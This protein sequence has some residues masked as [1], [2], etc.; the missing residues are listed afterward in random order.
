MFE[1]DINTNWR[2]LRGVFLL[3]RVTFDTFFTK[4]HIMTL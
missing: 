1:L 3:A 2:H 4:L